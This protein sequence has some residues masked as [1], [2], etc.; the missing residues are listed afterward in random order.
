M[1]DSVRAYCR[2]CRAPKVQDEPESDP[3]SSSSSS[4]GTTMRASRVLCCG[5]SGRALGAWVVSWLSLLARRVMGSDSLE[6][7][8][9]QRACD[10]R[11]S[12]SV[13]II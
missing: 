2:E 3:E 13:G 6:S 11:S 10:Y 12:L 9:V 1:D 8:H 5:G 4:V 7:E